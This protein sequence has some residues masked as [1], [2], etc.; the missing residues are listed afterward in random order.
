M[1]DLIPRACC[2]ISDKI[3]G[4][5]A[6]VFL[7]PKLPIKMPVSQVFRLHIRSKLHDLAQILLQIRGCQQPRC[8]RL[9]IQN[10]STLE[11]I[12]RLL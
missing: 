8:H 5:S 10:S 1:N 11:E 4:L 2:H 9:G 3:R 6:T 7:K 12:R